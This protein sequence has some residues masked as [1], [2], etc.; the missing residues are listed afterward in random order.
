MMMKQ[1]IMVVVAFGLLLTGCGYVPD[2][3]E[4][5]FYVDDP[6]PTYVPSPAPAGETFRLGT[7]NLQVYGDS[8]AENPEKFPVIS[9]L[10]QSFD[11]VVLQEIRDADGSSI[12]VLCDSLPEH[13][14]IFSSRA[15]NTQMKEQYVIAYKPQ[16]EY[17]GHK[18]YN[19]EFAGLFNRPPYL[20]TFGWKG[21]NF[22][23][24]T[25]HTDPDV[26]GPELAVIDDMFSTHQEN[27]FILGD[28]NSDCDYYDLPGNVLTD[29]TWHVDFDTTSSATDCAYDQI[30]TSKNND[31]G[32]LEVGAISINKSI[33]DHYPVY[34]EVGL[35]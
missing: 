30:L 35:V 26:V 19:P 10:V 29:F 3:V 28:L 8:K 32:I 7:W 1:G 22:S 2:D 24:I 18:D 31:F 21:V 13:E 23:L 17:L 15:G 14:C 5:L 4:S 20:A 11:I 34:A 27:L 12:G 25:I 33:S 6:V 16:F 9:E